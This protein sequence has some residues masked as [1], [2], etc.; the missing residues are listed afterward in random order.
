[1]KAAV[2][3]LGALIAS[4]QSPLTDRLTA[5]ALREDVSFLASDLLE[6]RETPSRGGEIAAAYIESAFR[7]ADLE[8][9]PNGEYSQIANFLQISQH[10]ETVTFSIAGTRE[11]LRIPG[12]RMFVESS[13][14]QNLTAEPVFKWAPSV[15]LDETLAGRFLMLRMPADRSV[16][17][18][19]ALTKPDAI[20]L[21]SRDA[22]GERNSPR[23]IPEDKDH[24]DGPVILIA[25]EAELEGVFD[26]LPNGLTTAKA[27]LQIGSPTIRPVQVRNV[28]GILRGS[29]AKLRDQ[30]IVVSAH[31]DHLGI[32]A[33][34]KDRIYNGANDDA[35]GVA[36][37]IELARAFARENPRPKRTLIFVCFFGEEEGLLGSAWYLKHPVFPL[38]KT[39]ADINFEQLGE[40]SESDGIPAG[41]IGVTGYGLSDL[42]EMMAPGL[43]QAGVPLREARHNEEFFERSDNLSFARAGIPSHTFVAALEFPDYHRVSDEWPKL[44]YD[45]MAKLDRGLALAILR[46]ANSSAMPHWNEENARA[47][48]Y[49]G[50]WRALHP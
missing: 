39:V 48:E 13:R 1:M 40:P 6:G 24:L 31:Y 37:V 28:V 47:K 46:L 18:K 19:L 11:P 8:S 27:S 4:A 12:A 44:D 32:A 35:S 2:L 14:A 36:T 33:E 50:A 22:R 42:P 38:D 26:R 23:L 34:G 21:L 20:I 25:P 9:P 43:Q 29:D 30:D 17:A 15:K 41:S 7:G 16:I 10:P 45:N 3:A 5:T 49:I